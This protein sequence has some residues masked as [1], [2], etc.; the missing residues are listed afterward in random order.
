ML[1]KDVNITSIK[2]GENIRQIYKED[3][4]SSLMQTIKDNGLL[5]PIGL[6]ELEKDKYKILWGNRRLSAFK[7]LGYKS[8]PS[9]IFANDREMTEEEFIVINSIENLQHSPNNLF[10]L[11]RICSILKKSMSISE[12]STRL[13]ITKNRVKFA[14]DEL[15]RLPIKWKNKVKQSNVSHEEKKG[16]IPITTAVKVTNLRNVKNEDKDKI[17]NYAIKNDSNFKRVE[18]I[19]SLV[20]TGLSVDKAIKKAEKYRDLRVFLLIQSKQ[21]DEMMKEYKTFTALVIHSLRKTYPNID[22]LENTARKQK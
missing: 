3:D 19:T 11:G 10:E 20:Q 5:Q 18:A 2:E 8:I 12:I 13:G 9:V 15:N 22:I 14:L 1:V 21:A 16:K 4:L 7:K 6:V 17:L